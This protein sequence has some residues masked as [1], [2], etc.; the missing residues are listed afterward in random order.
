MNFLLLCFIFELSFSSREIFLLKVDNNV[1]LDSNLSGRDFIGLFVGLH[2]AIPSD[3]HHPSWSEVYDVR[4]GS[5]FV[6]RLRLKH[7]E[8]FEV[9]Q[10]YKFPFIHSACIRFLLRRIL[11]DVQV[12]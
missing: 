10:G 2:R 6:F 9:A 11:E 7:H 1:R 8:S 3:S 5:F 4:D 12:E